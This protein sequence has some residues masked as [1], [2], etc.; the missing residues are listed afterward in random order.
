MCEKL[1]CYA[2]VHTQQNPEQYFN[3]HIHLT[4]VCFVT[5]KVKYT[6]HP[7]LWQTPW[8][9]YTGRSDSVGNILC[10]AVSFR[11]QNTNPLDSPDIAYTALYHNAGSMYLGL[12]R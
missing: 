5:L 2:H 3:P 10:K 11:C 1:C 7:K 12:Y 4:W 6:L 8:F 9:V